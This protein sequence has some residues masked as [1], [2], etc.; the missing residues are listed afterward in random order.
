M[1][2]VIL[3]GLFTA[4]GWLSGGYALSDIY[5]E[6][7]RKQQLESQ[8]EQDP[9]VQATKQ[10]KYRTIALIVSAVSLLAGFGLWLYSRKTAKK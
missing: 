6:K 9:A 7:Q 2:G 1:W 8:A 3:K 5:N 10:K 4:V